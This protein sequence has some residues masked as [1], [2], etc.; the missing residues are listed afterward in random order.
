MSVEEWLPPRN[1]VGYGQT[2]PISAWPN[3]KTIAV[4]FV[5]NYEEWVDTK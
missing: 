4:S 1:Y 2:D 3:G 5:L